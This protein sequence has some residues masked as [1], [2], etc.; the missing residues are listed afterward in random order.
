MEW[1][2]SVKFGS[3]GERPPGRQLSRASQTV[4]KNRPETAGE[5]PPCH[6]CTYRDLLSRTFSAAVAY[7]R[8]VLL[9]IGIVSGVLR[10]DQKTIKKHEGQ[11]AARVGPRVSLR[12]S[13]VVGNGRISRAAARSHILALFLLVEP[14]EDHQSNEDEEQDD[15]PPLEDATLAEP[16]RT[17]VLLGI[18]GENRND[19]RAE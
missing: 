14:V 3:S 12:R 1:V 4:L 16:W 5:D 17:F 6:C 13:I 9:G 8:Y 19:D 11:P 18:G 15:L 10:G 2:G 7:D